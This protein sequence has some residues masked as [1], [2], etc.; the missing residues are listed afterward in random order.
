[1]IQGIRYYKTYFEH[2]ALLRS[3]EINARDI[4]LVSFP[5]SGNTWLRFILARAL[6][7]ESQMNLR[8]I[9]RYFPTM[10]RTSAE[11]MRQIKSPRYIKTHAAYFSLYP[12]S[13]YI[14]R[15]YR[16]VVV[17][18]WHHAKNKISYSGTLSEFIRGPL[19]KSFGPWH[20]H[21][22]SAMN[23]QK[24]N[25]EKMLTLQYETML[26]QPENEIE[27]VL[28]FCKIDP[29]VSVAELI[30]LTSFGRLQSEEAK[31]GSRLQDSSSE[32]FF[33]KGTADNWKEILSQDDQRFLLNK[34]VQHVMQQCGYQF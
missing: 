31:S 12:R 30:E 28:R 32:H 11:E 34:S 29:I 17:S 24:R 3:A 16:A 6:Y 23:F 13:I 1:M 5:K 19:L 20:W 10:Y 21:V 33:R 8:N 15:D 2:R 7:P 4:F 27:R 18:A 9:Q 22:S 25:P 26:A 14:Y